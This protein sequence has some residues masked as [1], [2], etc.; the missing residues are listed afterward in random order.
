MAARTAGIARKLGLELIAFKDRFPYVNA[1]KGTLG[2]AGSWDSVILQLPPGPA[3]AGVI[4]A[5]FMTK[6]FKLICDVHTGM[7]AFR[8]AKQALLN[9]PFTRMLK[10]CNHVL[11]HNRDNAFIMKSLGLR[12]YTVIYDPMP[13]PAVGRKPPIDVNKYEYIIV[14]AGWDADE[15]FDYLISE[16][17]PDPRQTIGYR[18]VITGNYKRTRLG[19]T[20]SRKLARMRGV[21]LT[22]YLP[23]D[24]YVWLLRNSAAVLGMTNSEHIMLRAFWEAASYHRPVIAPKTRVTV[25]VMGAY[26]YYYRTYVR[27]SLRKAIS[28]LKGDPEAA[29]RRA[30]LLAS[31]MRNLSED[32]MERLKRIVEN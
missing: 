27:G 23:Q 6:D 5:K 28:E 30:S 31:R 16:I 22:G 4:L 18:V 11:A 14:P 21:V 8:D 26:P 20:Y 25:E 1:F 15:P 7:I 17:G 10:K 24:E 3:L 2:A 9:S 32:S 12:N 13:E 19:L 29:L